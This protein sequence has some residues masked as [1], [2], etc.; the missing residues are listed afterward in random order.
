M[1]KMKTMYMDDC[2]GSPDTINV[3]HFSVILAEAGKKPFAKDK[4]GN[5]QIVASK[6]IAHTRDLPMD[7]KTEP[8]TGWRP[9][10]AKRIG[11]LRTTAR[12][13]HWRQPHWYSSRRWW[14]VG[15]ERLF[16]ILRW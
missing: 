15:C 12:E 13:P 2:A 10:P 14:C 4:D 11:A 3:P 1:L 16:W 8:S 7:T 5:N 9:R 6:G